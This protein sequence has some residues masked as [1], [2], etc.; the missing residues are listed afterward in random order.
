MTASEL[1]AVATFRLPA[2]AEIAKG[3][4]D[5]AGIESMIRTD[6][7]G[8]MYPGIAGTQLLVRAEDAD[9]A[10]EALAAEAGSPEDA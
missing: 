1:V 2:E 3:M 9:S 7:I 10:R 5:Q 8:G 4:L 6:D